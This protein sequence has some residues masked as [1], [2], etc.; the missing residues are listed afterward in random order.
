L[1][2]KNFKKLA[3]LVYQE[4]PL[5][6]GPKDNS[7][8][9]EEMKVL[10]KDADDGSRNDFR[11]A[12][13]LLL[14]ILKRRLDSKVDTEVSEI[15]KK[16]N[17]KNS[18]SWKVINVPEIES[19]VGP[20]GSQE[21]VFYTLVCV[22]SGI[23]RDS[24]FLKDFAANSIDALKFHKSVM[25]TTTK[26]PHDHEPPKKLWA[27]SYIGVRREEEQLKQKLEK[28]ASKKNVKKAAEIH[29]DPEISGAQKNIFAPKTFELEILVADSMEYEI[30]L[31]YVY[32]ELDVRDNYIRP[33]Q[34]PGK[35]PF[36]NKLDQFDDLS[37]NDQ[38]RNYVTAY[39]KLQHPV[40]GSAQWDKDSFFKFF[41][42]L[43]VVFG[44]ESEWGKDLQKTFEPEEKK[45]KHEDM[46]TVPADGPWIDFPQLDS[47]KKSVT[48]DLIVKALLHC[49]HL[50]VITKERGIIMQTKR[51]VLSTTEGENSEQKKYETFKKAFNLMDSEIYSASHNYYTKR[52]VKEDKK[53]QTGDKCRKTILNI[54]KSFE[55]HNHIMNKKWTYLDTWTDK[56]TLVKMPQELS[57]ISKAGWRCPV[58]GR[59]EKKYKQIFF[60]KNVNSR[61]ADDKYLDL[62]GQ[63][64][65]RLPID[66]RC[67]FVGTKRPKSRKGDENMPNTQFPRDMSAIKFVFKPPVWLED[68]WR[69]KLDVEHAKSAFDQKEKSFWNCFGKA[70][71]GS[72]IDHEILIKMEIFA[73]A[74]AKIKM[75]RENKMML[76]DQNPWVSDIT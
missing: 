55:R 53:A 4:L 54:M 16:Y 51:G 39:V 70:A 26:K 17:I 43:L 36:L 57:V 33:D 11:K 14:K 22:V 38:L 6:F 9:D 29:A 75:E 63:E 2:E 35:N 56:Y 66:T 37:R 59:S 44:L 47:E 52:D 49:I 50:L 40:I 69:V 32:D 15:L 68:G 3:Q 28:I 18:N 42:K 72:S 73:S 7:M 41:L 76:L 34:L 62:N 5:T 12:R 13:G 65:Y 1:P 23:L 25:G 74:S 64:G 24:R 10:G 67:V 31:W 19:Q 30:D 20:Q 21:Q 60:N 58:P 27:H 46:T 48:L 8:I 71:K 61:S 45:P